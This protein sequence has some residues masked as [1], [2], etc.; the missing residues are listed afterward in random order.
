MENS[1]ATVM[2][3]IYPGFFIAYIIRISELQNASLLLFYFFSVVFVND[4]MAYIAG[5][6]IGRGTRMGLIIS[7]KKSLVG[8][9]FGF[10]GAVGISILYYYTIPGLFNIE[11]GGVIII[12]SVFGIVGILGDLVESALKRSAEVKD[13]GEI[14]P[15]RGG[16]LDSIDSMLFVAPIFYYIFKI[17]Q[18]YPG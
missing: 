12:G 6:S 17:S 7:P 3:A 2:A 9:I 15:G 11:I 1:A 4:I 14:I 8:F 18:K 5:L 16:L 13:S 10:L